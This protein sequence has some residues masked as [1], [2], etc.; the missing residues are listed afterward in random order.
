[1][2]I[3]EQKKNIIIDKNVYNFGELT[4]DFINSSTDDFKL[5]LNKLSYDMVKEI[6]KILSENYIRSGNPVVNETSDIKVKTLEQ[7]LYKKIGICKP[8]DLLILLSFV[9][10][11]GNENYTDFSIRFLNDIHI[12]QTEF[13]HALIEIFYQN[14]NKEDINI[15]IKNYNKRHSHDNIFKYFHQTTTTY[16][17]FNNSKLSLEKHIQLYDDESFFLYDFTNLIN[18]KLQGNNV[19]VK[20]CRNEKCDKYFITNK[21]DIAYCNLHKG[22]PSNRH[23][24]YKQKLKQDPYYR[25]Y[26]KAYNRIYKQYI[27]SLYKN[28]F[29]I[30]NNWHKEA[31]KKLNLYKSNNISHEDFLEFFKKE[32][33]P[34]KNKM[35]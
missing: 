17:K 9:R 24:S 11:I 13:T 10:S 30:F 14:T 7:E 15:Y 22:L 33:S 34:F 6:L 21:S 23:Y 5:L 16:Y 20:K 18:Y 35:A 28:S 29:D 12:I 25:E 8:T 27:N 2:E 4:I 26:Q 1:M 19:F 32:N 31:K 3:I